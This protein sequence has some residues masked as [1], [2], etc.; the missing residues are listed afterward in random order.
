MALFTRNVKKIKGAAHKN[1]DI[2]GACKRTLVK[3][4]VGISITGWISLC[5]NVPFTNDVLT[6]FLLKL[7]ENERK[8]DLE[9]RASL[10]S[11]LNPPVIRDQKQMENKN[12]FQ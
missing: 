4:P 6:Y 2:D 9:G 5:V 7:N 1:G 8:L 12:A 10:A 3:Y 11:P